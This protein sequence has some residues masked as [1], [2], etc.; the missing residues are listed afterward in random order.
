MS[1]AK[2]ERKKNEKSAR[3]REVLVATALFVPTLAF[4]LWFRNEGIFHLDAIFLAQAVE[5]IYTG[6]GWNAHWRFAAVLA[7]AL[8]YFPFWLAGESAERATVLAS[9]LF[10]A[11]S[12]PMTFFFVTRLSGSRVHGALS[13]GLLAF[14]PVC[15]ISNSFGKEY[16][17][18]MLLVVTALWLAVVAHDTGSAWRAALS[19]LLFALSYTVWEGLLAATPIYLVAL[20]MP[21]ASRL[22][23]PAPPRLR[24][25]LA[26]ATV[27]YAIG[28]AG[29]LATSLLAMLRVYAVA[30]HMTAFTGLGAASLLAA[31]SDL[32]R[33]LGRLTL[34]AAALGT[35]LAWHDRHSRRVLPIGVL[36]IA[37]IAFYGSLSTYGPRYL[38][39]G[40][41]GFSMLAGATYH[42]LLGQPPPLRLA[43]M[44]AYG[45][46]VAAMVWASYPLLE[47]RRTF[48][49]AKRFAH[50]IAE[51]TEPDSLII[52]MD[53]SR[54]VEYYAR[55]AT[56]GHPI[57]DPAATAAWA[58]ALAQEARRRPVYLTDSGLT[59]D[60]E[61][62][63][64]RALDDAFTR[65]LVG[66]HAT[67]D[68]HHAERRLQFYQGHLWRLVPR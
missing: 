43:A 24:R 46:T 2:G 15:T 45:M 21:R 50:F 5:D 58:R 14:A 41:L 59:Y 51:V 44:A 26:G 56:R 30:S 34:V 27:G 22:R 8:V 36:L 67:E 68:Y 16:G 4:M 20:L 32:L 25:L 35:V 19:A 57:G 6:N 53:D 28:L 54:F 11:V 13:A 63:A 61:R 3:G 12:V 37:T 40:A 39:L 62:T 55:R 1:M 29:G 18:A 10:H 9:V 48:N 47:P 60:S 7:N 23:L 42:F 33:F 64:A 49:G 66:T 65:V 17:L 52:V 31:V 38:A